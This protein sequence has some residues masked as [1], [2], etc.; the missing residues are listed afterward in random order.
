MNHYKR[1]TTYVLVKP[2]HEPLAA[3]AF[4]EHA[5]V[6]QSDYAWYE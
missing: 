2:S 5:A 4:G 3:I 6:V 1:L